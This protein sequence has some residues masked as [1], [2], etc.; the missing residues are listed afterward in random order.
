MTNLGASLGTALAGSIMIAVVT[1][2]FLADIQKSPAI[3]QEVKSQ[4]QVELADG[5]P[6]VSDADLHAALDKANANSAAAEDAFKAY[7]SARIVG[8]Q[9]GLAIVAV[10]CVIALFFVQRIP[11]VQPGAAVKGDEADNQD[12][13]TS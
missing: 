13:T 6:F 7:S 1:S 12:P 9:A 4:A 8:L 10:L 11:V 2:A 5:V 3:P